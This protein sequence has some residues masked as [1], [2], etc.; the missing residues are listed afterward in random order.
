[1]W[2]FG[3]FEYDT[4]ISYKLNSNFVFLKREIL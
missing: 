3:L 1:M 2:K 4:D